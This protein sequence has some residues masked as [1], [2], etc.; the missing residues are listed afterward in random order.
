MKL[1]N[2]SRHRP[3]PVKRWSCPRLEELEPR[4]APAV[5]SAGP[6]PVVTPTASSAGAAGTLSDQAVFTNVGVGRTVNGTNSAL[7]ANLNPFV[8]N[9]GALSGLN[10]FQS[11]APRAVADPT[12]QIDLLTRLD[13]LARANADATRAQLLNEAAVR[14]LRNNFLQS[15]AGG[16]PTTQP[17]MGSWFGMRG[18]RGGG[19]AQEEPVARAETQAPAVHPG[20]SEAA[21]S[22]RDGAPPLAGPEEEVRTGGKP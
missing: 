4:N 2:T 20:V 7:N 8:V 6:A 22:T 12:A 13:D 1:W 3:E 10:E 14:Q 16:E 19:E 21:F 9:G 17:N 15:G 18:S 11:S 5:V